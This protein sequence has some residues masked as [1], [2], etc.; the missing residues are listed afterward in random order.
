MTVGYARVSTNEQ[1]LPAQRDG[2]AALTVVNRGLTGTNRVRPGL[3]EALAAVRNR[4]TLVVTKL[5]RLSRSLPDTRGTADER[6]KR[7]LSLSLGSRAHYPTHPVGRVLFQPSSAWSPSAKP[8]SSG[9]APA[10]TRPSGYGRSMT[11]SA[12]R[13][14]LVPSQDLACE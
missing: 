13:D 8:T 9:C 1:D 2:F 12:F 7:N 10:K 6:T 5:D 11:V 14:R 4:D 3:R